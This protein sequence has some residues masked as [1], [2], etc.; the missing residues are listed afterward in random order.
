MKKLVSICLQ[1]KKMS[2]NMSSNQHIV[3]ELW[4]G[5]QKATHVRHVV[6]WLGW[7]PEI[8]LEENDHEEMSAIL[9]K[10]IARAQWEL[11]SELSQGR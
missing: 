5:C 10:V 7:N 3:K 4:G 8:V 2:L 9:E 1:E 6:P 11:L